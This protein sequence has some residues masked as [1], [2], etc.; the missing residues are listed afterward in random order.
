MDHGAD[1]TK[2]KNSSADIS[3]TA[4][5]CHVARLAY[6]SKL[7]RQNKDLQQF[8]TLSVNG[9]EVAFGSIGRRKYF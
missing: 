7:F 1:L 3:P 6:A 9:N 4:A 8:T 2:Q 5:R